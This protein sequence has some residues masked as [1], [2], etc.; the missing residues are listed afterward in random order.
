MGDSRDCSGGGRGRGEI[1]IMN[2]I[3]LL[4]WRWRLKWHQSEA[5]WY[6]VVLVH[7]DTARREHE[8]SALRARAR[9]DMCRRRV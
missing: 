1:I 7:V 9:A 5:D 6:Q 8:H 4:Y 3:R 2:A